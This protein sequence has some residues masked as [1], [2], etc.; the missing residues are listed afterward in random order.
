MKFVKIFDGDRIFISHDNF[1]SKARNL[2]VRCFTMI[3]CFNTLNT[4]LKFQ[5]FWKECYKLYTIS[6]V[7]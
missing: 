3:H 7:Y 1:K 5:Q 6:T 2:P 4:L